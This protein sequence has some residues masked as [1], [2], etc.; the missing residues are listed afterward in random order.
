MTRQYLL[1]DQFR[2][3][4]SGSPRF[5]NICAIAT[6]HADG[7]NPNPMHRPAPTFTQ[8]SIG[9]INTRSNARPVMKATRT[10]EAPARV[11][12]LAGEKLGLLRSERPESTEGALNWRM[13]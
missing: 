11:T 5:L 8:S 2:P 6:T 13:V 7:P 10:R 9:Q 1:M 12:F 3:Q 4:H